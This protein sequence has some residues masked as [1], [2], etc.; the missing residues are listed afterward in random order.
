M[1]SY[2]QK[3]ITTLQGI[4]IY[5]S[6]KAEQDEAMKELKAF[7]SNPQFN[8][9]NLSPSTSVLPQFNVNRRSQSRPL[10]VVGM[11]GY[12]KLLPKEQELCSKVRFVPQNYLEIKA[13]LIAENKK[14]GCVR[15]ATARKML[16]IDVNKT[17]KLYDFLAEEG[18]ITKSVT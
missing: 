10:D 12:E 13:M 4:E 17:R 8:W 7:E 9:K 2:R 16:K 15:L 5:E 14:N 1:I 11:P 6:I 3:G 18:Y